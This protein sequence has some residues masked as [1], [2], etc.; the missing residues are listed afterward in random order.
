MSPRLPKLIK[1]TVSST[2]FLSAVFALDAPGIAEETP[3]PASTQVP[4]KTR[5]QTDLHTA[6]NVNDL[7]ITMAES[8]MK[9][10]PSLRALGELSSALE[11]YLTKNCFGNLLQTLHY[12]GPPTDP[13]CIAR[14]E[15]LLEVYPSNPVAVCLRDGIAAETCA[16]AYKNQTLRSFANSSS[17]SN[18]DPALK[19]GLSA[20]DMKKLRALEDTL[21]HVNSDYQKASNDDEKQKFMD[22]ASRLYDQLLSIACRV[23]VLKLEEPESSMRAQQEEPSVREARERLLALPAG[24]RSEY[25]RKMLLDAEAE[26]AREAKNPL[27]QK[28]I[29]KKIEAIQNPEKSSTL[30]ASGKLRVRIVLPECE[31]YMKRASSILPNFPSPTCHREGWYSPNCIDAIKQWH[32]YHSR[33]REQ[34]AKRAGKKIAPTPNPLISSF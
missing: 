17:D 3:T 11:T 30:S 5:S 33:V 32:A 4:S 18:L 20:I 10:N 13:N 7:S 22:D 16:G 12:D 14:M 9:M 2:L 28:I 21:S 27:A 29:L 25:Q 24:L 31:D 34:A 15:R 8:S 1:V 23:V 19:V 26:L 6:L